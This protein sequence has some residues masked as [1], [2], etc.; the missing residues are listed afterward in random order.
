MAPQ[1][2]DEQRRFL[3]TEYERLKASGTYNFVTQVRQNFAAKYPEAR[4][5]EPISIRRMVAKFQTHNTVSN[6]NK[7]FCGR[8]VTVTGPDIQAEKYECKV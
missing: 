4:V 3:V 2:T 5:P 8:P 6:I 1:F 7:D